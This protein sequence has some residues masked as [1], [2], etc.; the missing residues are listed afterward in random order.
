MPLNMV[1]AGATISF[2]PIFASYLVA[3]RFFVEGV[4]SS[5][6]KG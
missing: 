4:T 5:G 3:Q 6:I 2:V 1:L